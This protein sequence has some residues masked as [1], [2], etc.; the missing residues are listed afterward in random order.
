MYE[1]HDLEAKDSN[2]VTKVSI[3]HLYPSFEPFVSEHLLPFATVS[4]PLLHIHY[5]VLS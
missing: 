1:I 5:I 3:P 4:G 2:R